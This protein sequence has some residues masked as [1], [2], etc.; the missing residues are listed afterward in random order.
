MTKKSFTDYMLPSLLLQHPQLDLWEALQKSLQCVCVDLQGLIK[1]D[2]YN[3]FVSE[4]TDM[5][6]WH[7]W[8]TNCG[9]KIL[10]FKQNMVRKASQ[11]IPQECGVFYCYLR[12]LFGALRKLFHGQSMRKLYFLSQREAVKQ[13]NKNRFQCLQGR[14]GSSERQTYHSG[15]LVRITDADLDHQEV[16]SVIPCPIEKNQYALLLPT[17]GSPSFPRDLKVAYAHPRTMKAILKELFCTRKIPGE[18]RHI[19]INFLLW[20]TSRWP[21]DKRLVVPE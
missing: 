16:P 7:T 21:W 4:C 6:G 14:T 2:F 12:F 19:N 9:E 15:Q 1:I 3:N 11:N 8:R 10:I 20:L 18:K 17:R 13:A 5:L